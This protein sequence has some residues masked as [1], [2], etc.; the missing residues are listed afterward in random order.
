MASINMLAKDMAINLDIEKQASD[1][2]PE[3]SE[4]EQRQL[5]LEKM[6]NEE[7]NIQRRLEEDYKM[8]DFA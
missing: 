6:I 8:Y 5:K 2:G 3:L 1:N 4:E 7:G